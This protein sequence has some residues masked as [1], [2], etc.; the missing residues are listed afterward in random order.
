M[1]L[2]LE[3]RRVEM[4]A[5]FEELLEQAWNHSLSPPLMRAVVRWRY[6]D[7]PPGGGTW[8][9]VDGDRC[10][11]L[12]DSFVRPYVAWGSKIMV[13]ET[14]DW[15]CLPKYRPLGVGIK[16][17]KKMMAFPEPVLSIGG[18]GA[19]VAILP[20]LRWAALPDVRKYV[21][22]NKV[23]GLVGTL[24]RKRSPTHEGIARAIPNFVP[25][26]GPRRA[27]PP[28]GFAARV[29]EWE[30][31]SPVPPLLGT[32]SAP[33]GLVEILE[34]A[35]LR[36][37]SEMPEGFARPFGLLFFLDDAPVGFSLS[38][39]EPVASGRDASIIHMQIA[40]A[41]QPVVD[42]IVAETACRLAELGAGLIRCRAS[43]PEKFAALEATGFLLRE[44][45][46]AYWWSNEGVPAPPRM[47]VGYLRADD[48]F[49][50]P[51]LRGRRL[52]PGAS[53][54]ARTGRAAA[55][56]GE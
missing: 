50:F 12:V 42:W 36:W 52:D 25:F 1:A 4:Q 41:D 27:R 45:Q 28:A 11:A 20:R 15:F 5:G 19:T 56:S 44:S 14:A 3:P 22:P 43:S 23:R 38:Q 51:A 9:A 26:R 24:L 13:R 16:L 21:L 33:Q 29:R 18:S 8:L 6:D 40:R 30:T 47:D 54:D 7:R 48:A 37:L 10:V 46:P 49:P 17:M 34:P 39:L 53:V 35:H 2:R 31:G 55:F 32:P